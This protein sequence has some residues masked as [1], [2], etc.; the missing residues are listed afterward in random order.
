[1]LHCISHFCKLG[2]ISEGKDA[3]QNLFEN[4]ATS[5]KNVSKLCMRCCISKWWDMMKTYH[6]GVYAVL[7]NEARCGDARGNATEA[8]IQLNNNNTVTDGGW[9]WVGMGFKKKSYFASMENHILLHWNSLLHY[10]RDCVLKSKCIWWFS[11][12]T[13]WV[14]KNNNILYIE[15]LTENTKRFHLELLGDSRL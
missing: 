14:R 11:Q 2:F 13:G 8:K 6:A 12:Q 1:M 3:R 5:F 9:G 7:G 15:Y 4:S 10:V